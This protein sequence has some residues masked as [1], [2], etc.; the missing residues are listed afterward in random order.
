[1]PD[2]PIFCKVGLALVLAMWQSQ[3]EGVGIKLKQVFIVLCFC[4]VD[5]IVMRSPYTSSY[6]HLAVKCLWVEIVV[7]WVTILGSN[8]F[9]LRI[10]PSQFTCQMYVTYG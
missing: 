9:S 7:G 4:W 3:E 10:C 5:L 1:M 6:K 2:D 8:L